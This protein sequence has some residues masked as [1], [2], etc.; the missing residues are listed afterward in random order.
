[1]LAEA[2]RIIAS[3]AAGR[4]VARPP[5][6]LAPLFS[7]TAQPYLIAWFRHDPVGELKRTRVPALAIQGTSDPQIGVED[8]RALA[9]ARDGI[10]LVLVPGMNHVLRDA[11][12]GRAANLATYGN[13]SLP[14]SRG[15]V[16]AVV[17]FVRS[18]GA[19]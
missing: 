4:T 1:M 7:E 12:A 3:L 6:A 14:L 2:D 8:A 9:A 11:P 17:S 10:S 19:R 5:P 15:L 16:D 18:A 13:A